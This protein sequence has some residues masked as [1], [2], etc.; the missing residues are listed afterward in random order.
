MKITNKEYLMDVS[1]KLMVEDVLVGG[2]FTY[3]IC[4]HIEK[5]PKRDIIFVYFAKFHNENNKQG[6]LDRYLN[7]ANG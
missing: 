4:I 3:I 5:N 7:K 6:I 2:L 1:M